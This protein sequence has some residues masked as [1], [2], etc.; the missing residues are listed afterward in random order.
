[1]RPRSGCGYQPR[2]GAGS[3]LA[4]ESIG[5]GLIVDMSRHFNRVLKVDAEAGEVV[6]EPGVVLEQL[7][8]QLAPLGKQVGPDP[9]SGNRATIG[10]MSTKKG[11]AANR[12][13]TAKKNKHDQNQEAT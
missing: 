3:G 11:K 8:W 12:K 9:A 5:A 7:N 6:V 13:A 10:G 4:G 2:A 1:M